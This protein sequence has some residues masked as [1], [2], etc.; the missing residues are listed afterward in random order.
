MYFIGSDGEPLYIEEDIPYE[1]LDESGVFSNGILFL[2]TEGKTIFTLIHGQKITISGVYASSS[3]WI[4][5]EK[6]NA[7]QVSFTDSN[8]DINEGI[9]ENG[10]DT[11]VRLVGE[12]ARTF[13]FEFEL[14]IPVPTSVDI[15]TGMN[16]L[17][18]YSLLA[19]LA[20]LLIIEFNRNRV[21]RV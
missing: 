12:D 14:Y 11:G 21:E 15:D 9:M 5:A 8:M 16:A 1:S 3:I 10:Y 6:E 4:I 20:G 17:L 13:D 18:L 7:Y 19:I 2:D